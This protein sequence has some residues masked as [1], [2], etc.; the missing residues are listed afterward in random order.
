MGTQLMVLKSSSRSSYTRALSAS[1]CFIKQGRRNR[2]NI[3]DSRCRRRVRTNELPFRENVRKTVVS[4]LCGT[5]VD[6]VGSRHEG[7]GFGASS[8][9]KVRLEVSRNIAEVNP[10]LLPPRSGPRA[11]AH[12]TH[13]RFPG[14]WPPWRRSRSNAPAESEGATFT[15]VVSRH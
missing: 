12:L 5:R 9:S 1:L 10:D 4:C 3:P 15:R 6:V 2:R 7:R 13:R 8:R 11:V 14:E